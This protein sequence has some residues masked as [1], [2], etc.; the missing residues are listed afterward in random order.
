MR[1]KVSIAEAVGLRREWEILT[2]N[3]VLVDAERINKARERM[4]Q[5]RGPLLWLCKENS[6]EEGTSRLCPIQ[7]DAGHAQHF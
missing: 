3:D 7:N 6:I 4:M 5:N 1:R 2:L